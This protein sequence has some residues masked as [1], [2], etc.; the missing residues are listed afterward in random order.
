MN[1][2]SLTVKMVRTANVMS[3]NDCGE[4]R[5]TVLAGGLKTT[6]CVG[7][8]GGGRAVTIAL[9]LHSG[10]HASGVASPEFDIGVSHRLATRCVD[11]IDVKVGD[12]TLLASEDIRSDQLASNP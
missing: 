5:S 6:K 3:W 12:S 8:D 10:V 7:G 2:S 4:G 1:M 9:G 11:D